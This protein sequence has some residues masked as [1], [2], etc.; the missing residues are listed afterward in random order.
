MT[1]LAAANLVVQRLGLGQPAEILPGAPAVGGHA[2]RVGHA[3]MRH[4]GAR[5][6]LAGRASRDSLPLTPPS[7]PT[8]H[9]TNAILQWSLTNRTWPPPRT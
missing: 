4:A 6:G 7:L 5:G 1:G 9:T 8:P 2:G 3:G